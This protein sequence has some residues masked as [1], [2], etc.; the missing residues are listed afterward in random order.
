[1]PLVLID[2]E[3]PRPFG[4]GLFADILYLY[5]GQLPH[6]SSSESWIIEPDLQ[7][8]SILKYE[9]GALGDDRMKSRCWN[10]AVKI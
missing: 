3:S 10:L 5:S 9:Y 1:L 2:K 6:N 7:V 4:R 8:I